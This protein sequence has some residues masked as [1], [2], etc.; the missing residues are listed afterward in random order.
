MITWIIE[1]L[2]YDNTDSNFPKK[3]N[4]LHIR[5]SHSEGPVH[6]IC[7]QVPEPEE[8]GTYTPFDDLT[9]EWAINLW[10]SIKVMANVAVESY[11]NELVTSEERGLKLPWVS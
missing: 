1:A 7:V 6:F 3:V 4:F 5:A 8:G 11:L 9:E 10:E 2:E